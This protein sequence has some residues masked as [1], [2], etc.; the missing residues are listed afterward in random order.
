MTAAFTTYNAAVVIEEGLGQHFRAISSPKRDVRSSRATFSSNFVAQ[1]E[2]KEFS[3][4]VFERF[5]R[6]RGAQ[7]VIGQRFGAKTLPKKHA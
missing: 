4:N 1:E 7:R 2:R 3:G 6:P 5:R